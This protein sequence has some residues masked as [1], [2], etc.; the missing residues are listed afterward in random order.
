MNPG[1]FHGDREADAD[2]GFVWISHLLG[3]LG[4]C[5]GMLA[6]TPGFARNRTWIH[7]SEP[8]PSGGRLITYVDFGGIHVC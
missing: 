1:K 5:S 8:L 6:A 7:Y 4:R 2:L 3:L